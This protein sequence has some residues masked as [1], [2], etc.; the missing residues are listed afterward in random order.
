MR[1]R[2]L[3]LIVLIALSVIFGLFTVPENMIGIIIGCMLLAIAE[4]IKLEEGKQNKPQTW[5]NLVLVVIGAFMIF[6]S[7]ISIPYVSAI[8]LMLVMY[9]VIKYNI[10]SK[11]D[12][13]N[14]SDLAVRQTKIVE[15]DLDSHNLKR[16]SF[17]QFDQ[18]FNNGAQHEAIYTWENVEMYH[19]YAN[20]FIDFG[21]TIVPLG[22]NVVVINQLVGTTKLVIPEG[23]GLSLHVNGFRSDVFWDGQKTVLN[24]DRT[25]IETAEYD[26]ANRKIYLQI[27]QGWGTVE[28]I[29]L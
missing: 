28:V 2:I 18:L 22:T 27:S 17:L 21:S 7:I 15:D 29:F 11:D 20:T 8:I 6:I 12:V 1:N 10:S 5:L 14:R 19:I 3:I 24:N 25:Q 9:I 26:Q 23:V 13:Q 4:K 16:K